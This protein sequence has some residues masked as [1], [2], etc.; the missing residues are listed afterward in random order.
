MGTRGPVPKR[1]TERRRRND[2]GEGISRAPAGTVVR[3]PAASASWHPLARKMYLA[4]KS[5]GQSAFFEPSDWAAAQ[6]AAEATSRMLEA[7]K[8]SAMLLT[9]VDGMWARLLVT[10]ADRR[11]LKIELERPDDGAEQAEYNAKVARMASYRR[12]TGA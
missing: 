9:A 10:E 1:S 7:E 6:L 11:R 2:A 8:L 4:L 5:S 12:K 3:V